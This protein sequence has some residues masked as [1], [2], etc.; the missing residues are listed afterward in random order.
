MKSHTM[1]L[2]PLLLFM[3][4]LTGCAGQQVELS[5]GSTRVEKTAAAAASGAK[6]IATQPLN[7]LNLVREEIPAV[8][9]AARTAP[10]EQPQGRSCSAVA[11][12]LQALD[13]ALGPE[14][15]AK[16]ADSGMVE[17]AATLAGDVAVGTVKNTVNTMVNGVVPMRDWVRK[18]SGAEEHSGAVTAA[19]SAGTTRRTFLK[20]WAA[21]AGCSTQDQGMPASG[22]PPAVPVQMPA[23]SK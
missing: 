18:L 8:L 13:Q 6:Q 7:D 5:D 23:G 3:L 21:G 11:T 15:N 2:G 22:V 12:E 17:K 1:G 20:G 19:I 9:Q 16:V 14:S 10:Y 4:A